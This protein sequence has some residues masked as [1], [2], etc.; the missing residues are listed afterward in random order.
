MRNAILILCYA[1]LTTAI[2][3]EAQDKADLTATHTVT[4]GDYAAFLLSE[5]F[6]FRIATGETDAKPII[7]FN[8]VNMQV[9]DINLIESER[10][11]NVARLKIENLVK[12]IQKDAIPLL[13]RH[14]KVKTTGANFRVYYLARKDAGPPEVVMAWHDGEYLTPGR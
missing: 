3:A 14:M 11:V 8:P 2:P 12:W 13:E 5:A 9:I 10:N 6:K 7:V 1:T 4:A